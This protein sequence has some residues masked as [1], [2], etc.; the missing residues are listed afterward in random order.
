MSCLNKLRMKLEMLYS[1]CLCDNVLNELLTFV[2]FEMIYHSL[3]H[4]TNKRSVKKLGLMWPST[5]NESEWCFRN[6]S[7]TNRK[8]SFTESKTDI[9]RMHTENLWLIDYDSKYLWVRFPFSRT[10]LNVKLTL[11]SFSTPLKARGGNGE[12][13]VCLIPL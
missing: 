13:A 4:Y 12:L 8:A 10:I 3:A 6:E 5:K 9:I 11:N 2:V 7:S 1:F